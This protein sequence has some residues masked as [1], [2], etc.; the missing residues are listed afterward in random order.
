MA[1]WDVDDI[2]FPDRLERALEAQRSGF[3]FCCSYILLIDD[4]LEVVGARGFTRDESG[5]TATFVH[6]TLSCDLELARRVGYS[7]SAGERPDHPPG[8]HRARGKWI[9]DALL[10]HQFVAGGRW[11]KALATNRARRAT[12]RTLRREGLVDHGRWTSLGIAARLSVKILLLRALGIA[13]DLYR[14][15]IPLRTRGDLDPEW[16]LSDEKAAFLALLRERSRRADWPA[17]RSPSTEGP[18]TR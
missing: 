9:R 1:I 8:V 17:G 3:D 10:A 4:D 11:D 6:G 2:D 15:T 16:S 13:P 5:R 7:R 18:S 12:Y 14:M